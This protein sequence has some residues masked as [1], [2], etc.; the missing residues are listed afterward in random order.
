MTS[1]VADPAD[2]NGHVL[3]RIL[4]EQVKLY[5]D[6]IAASKMWQEPYP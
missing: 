1:S 6:P 2:K 4:W 3:T 5:N